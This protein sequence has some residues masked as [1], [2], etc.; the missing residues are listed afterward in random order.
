[1]TLWIHP[2][3]VTFADRTLTPIVSLRIERKAERIIAERHEGD[4]QVSFADACGERLE[5]TVELEPTAWPE[6]MPLGC[7]GEIS[8]EAS[9]GAADG[10]RVRVTA[11][12]VLIAVQDLATPKTGMRR[13]L[14]F[15]LRATQGMSEPLAV[16]ALS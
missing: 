9:L 7:E 14:R 4:V 3:N 12:A 6:S 1:M 15:L 16:E 11:T 8:F 10:K 2:N 13:Q 5:M